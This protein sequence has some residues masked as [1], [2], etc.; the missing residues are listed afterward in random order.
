MEIKT[1]TYPCSGC[2]KC[3]HHCLHGVLSLVDNGSCR[4]VNVTDASRCSGCGRCERVPEL[5]VAAVMRLWNWIVPGITRW[6]SIT[7]WQAL[8]VALLLRLLTGFHPPMLPLRGRR[9]MHEKMRRMS[10]GERRAFIHS[11]LHKLTGEE[12]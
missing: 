12:S 7:Y 5:L 2:G 8:G 1:F 11:Q 3:V 6:T 10:M 9:H 4:F